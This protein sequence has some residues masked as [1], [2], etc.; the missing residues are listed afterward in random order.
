MLRS[1]TRS[2]NTLPR[3]PP[4]AIRMKMNSV[5]LMLLFLPQLWSF[6]VYP[7]AKENRFTSELRSAELNDRVVVLETEMSGMKD[8]VQALRGEMQ[9]G[10]DRLSQEIKELNK[11]LSQEIKEVSKEIKEVNKQLSQEIKEVNKQ[12]SQ[13]IKDLSNKFTPIYVFLA[14]T[15]TATGM[16]NFKDFVAFFK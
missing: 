6:S 13:E 15:A 9:Q 11:Q 5:V 10:T 12:L 14:V 4:Q 3:Q 7:G 2:L 1:D 8:D 16:A